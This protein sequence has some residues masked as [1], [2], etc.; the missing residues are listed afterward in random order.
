MKICSD[1]ILLDP[2]N[3]TFKV[4]PSQIDKVCGYRDPSACHWKDNKL[5]L[6]GG[7]NAGSTNPCV[8]TVSI[9]TL[10]G[11]ESESISSIFDLI[12]ISYSSL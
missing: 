4:I 2:A 10:K 7:E 11:L 5:I 12:V 6:F 8:S 1:L 3:K 9:L